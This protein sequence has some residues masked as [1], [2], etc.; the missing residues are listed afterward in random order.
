[1]YVQCTSVGSDAPP[2]SV[3]AHSVRI[4]RPVRLLAR[5]TAGEVGNVAF[6]DLV[7]LVLALDFREVGGRGSHR[8]FAHP[9]VAE[10]VNL[11]SESGQAKR[12]QVRQV[13]ALIRRYDLR[14]EGRR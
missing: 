3:A 4:M 6:G 10:L 7:A 2:L 12:Y 13:A 1:M 8:V 9:E 5:V 14:L 11:Q